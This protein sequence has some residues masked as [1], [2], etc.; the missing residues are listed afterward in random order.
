MKDLNARDNVSFSSTVDMTE[1]L[2][3]TVDGRPSMAFR[4]QMALTPISSVANG[5][6][7]AAPEIGSLDHIL[8]RLKMDL[9]SCRTSTMYHITKR[10]RS[11]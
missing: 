9:R 11:T 5:S 4:G 10:R 7:S 2:V 1:S 6:L 3:R 8:G